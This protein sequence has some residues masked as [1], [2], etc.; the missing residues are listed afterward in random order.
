MAMINKQRTFYEFGPFRIDPD[1]R[2]LLREN[3]P[4]PLQ[5]KAF[6]ILLALIRNQE[7]V[8]LKDD[9]LKTVWPETFIEESTLAQNIYYP[10]RARTLLLFSLAEKSEKSDQN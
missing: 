8:V 4:V 5:P 3:Q 7:N 1:H 10:E 9:L 6:D 2:L